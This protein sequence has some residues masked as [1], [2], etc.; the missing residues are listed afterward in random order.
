M[1]QKRDI[2][3]FF[4]IESYLNFAIRDLFAVHADRDIRIFFSE[5]PNLP[6][7]FFRVCPLRP[8]YIYEDLIL[9]I[10]SF[11]NTLFRF[12]LGDLYGIRFK[13]AIDIVV[14]LMSRNR[15]S[16]RSFHVF[17]APF[18]FLAV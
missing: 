9:T 13:R 17:T 10:L 2:K 18:F 11:P 15:Q 1:P 6:E 8:V 3:D 4:L 14:L 12:A 5:T 16:N 7:S